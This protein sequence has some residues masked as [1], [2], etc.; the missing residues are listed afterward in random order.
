MVI[1]NSGANAHRKSAGRMPDDPLNPR[2][3]A[4]SA[5]QAQNG[6][7]GP[8]EDACLEQEGAVQVGACHQIPH[9][10]FGCLSYGVGDSVNLCLREVGIGQC[11]GN[12]VSIE[13]E[14]MVPR[15]G[16]IAGSQSAGGLLAGMNSIQVR[17]RPVHAVRQCRH[18]DEGYGGGNRSPRA[19]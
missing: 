7:T 2:S 19:A 15:A 3:E 12:R 18:L 16:R 17:P 5:E 14:F 1:A 8:D 10:V 9:F 13:H 11:A 6:D 4:D